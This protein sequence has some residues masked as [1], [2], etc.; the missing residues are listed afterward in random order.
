M[1]LHDVQAGEVSCDAVV[2]SE[3]QRCTCFFLNCICRACEAV[4]MGMVLA[5]GNE[6]ACE[7]AALRMSRA[8]S[9][10]QD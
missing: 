2:P 4:P 7:R 1:A 10:S 3:F 5:I 9:A 8:P 6:R